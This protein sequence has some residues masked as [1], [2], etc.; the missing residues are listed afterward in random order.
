ME[1]LKKEKETIEEVLKNFLLQRELERLRC[2]GV[3]GKHQNESLQFLDVNGHPHHQNSSN[4][5]NGKISLSNFINV[6]S[7]NVSKADIK[8]ILEVT[9]LS[10][11]INKLKQVNV[12]NLAQPMDTV[13]AQPN[14]LHHHPGPG[15]GHSQAPAMHGN[16]P[17]QSNSTGNNP[18]IKLNQLLS[19]SQK[20]NCPSFNNQQFT[21]KLAATSSNNTCKKESQNQGLSLISSMSSNQMV[22]TLENT[23]TLQQNINVLNQPDADKGNESLTQNNA[24]PQKV[25]NFS[26][27]LQKF[28]GNAP[29]YAG[30]GVVH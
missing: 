9:D 4:V 5:S 28:T 27:D 2:F 7:N 18:S 16:P 24:N 21:Q 8:N 22:Y 1:E 6:E 15:Q 11:K 17:S 12:A 29:S 14:P 3:Q 19:Q 26:F 30:N 25:K 10:S 23:P 20:E 13:S